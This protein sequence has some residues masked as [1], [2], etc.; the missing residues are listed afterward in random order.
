MSLISAGFM[1]LDSTFNVQG[2]GVKPA[3]AARVSAEVVQTGVREARRDKHGSASP[4]KTYGLT[5]VHHNFQMG[6]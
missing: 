5:I 1:S 6:R 4:Q 3:A 2:G